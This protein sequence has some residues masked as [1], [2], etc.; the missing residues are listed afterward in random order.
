[1]SLLLLSVTTSQ[2]RMR[3]APWPARIQKIVIAKKTLTDTEHTYSVNVSLINSLRS[4][5]KY[6]LM[7]PNNLH[8]T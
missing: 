2:Y 8:I 5:Q 6:D 4:S 1:M 3:T 7:F